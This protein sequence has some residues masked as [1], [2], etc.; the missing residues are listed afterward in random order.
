MLKPLYKLLVKW[1][2]LEKNP[3]D[4]TQNPCEDACEHEPRPKG[5]PSKF[6]EFLEP[7]YLG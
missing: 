2:R 5:Q 3:C 6:E 4:R 1:A 7:S